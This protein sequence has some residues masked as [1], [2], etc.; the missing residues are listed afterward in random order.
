[1]PIIDLVQWAPQ[2]DETIVAYRFPETNLSTFTQLIT[3][4]A[5]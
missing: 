5:L 2:G 3:S 1:M 4:V